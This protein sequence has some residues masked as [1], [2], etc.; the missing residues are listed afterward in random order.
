MIQ[1]VE[2]L[3][4]KLQLERVVNWEIAMSREVP[5]CSSKSAQSITPKIALSCRLMVYW[6]NW[7]AGEGRWIESFPPWVLR[8]IQVK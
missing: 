2:H 1:H 3:G 6:I 8:A 5:L 4:S 7:R